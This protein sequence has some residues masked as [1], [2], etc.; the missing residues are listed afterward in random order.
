MQCRIIELDPPRR[1][2]FAWSDSGGVTMTSSRR[3]SDVLLTADPPR[4]SGPRHAPHVSAGWHAHLDILDARLAGSEPAPFWDSWRRLRAD[5]D[6][7][8]PPEAPARSSR[9][10]TVVHWSGSGVAVRPPPP[11]GATDTAGRTG[12]RGEKICH[13][14]VVFHLRPAAEN[15]YP[16][17]HRRR[18]RLDACKKSG[19]GQLVAPQVWR[20]GLFLCPLLFDI[21]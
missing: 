13:G 3:A 8:S 11:C 21:Y 20:D 14:M 7:R 6:A 10:A 1:L 15:W 16:A 2:T 17:L 12:G 4:H 5:Y 18:G 19:F 9:H